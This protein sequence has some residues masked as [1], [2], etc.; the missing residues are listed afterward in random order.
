MLSQ[1]HLILPIL[2]MIIL[3]IFN[4]LAYIRESVFMDKILICS[5]ILTAVFI[6]KVRQNQ[7]N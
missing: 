1:K 7:M 6:A 2:G 4:A 5:F 3:M